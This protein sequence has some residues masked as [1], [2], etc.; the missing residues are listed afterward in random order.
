MMCEFIGAL[1]GFFF[2]MSK[3]Q[4]CAMPRDKEIRQ[5]FPSSS[6]T[7]LTLKNAITH[8]ELQKLPI[9]KHSLGHIMAK[10]IL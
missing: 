2:F 8:Q 7:I 10:H 6:Y 5:A 1:W 9:W 3:T 4:T